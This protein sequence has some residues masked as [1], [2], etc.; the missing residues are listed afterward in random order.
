MNL[1]SIKMRASK[2]E[3]HISGGERIVNQDLLKD[4]VIQLIERPKDFDFMN[5]KIQ[6]LTE[7]RYIPTGL[8]I[9]TY[10]FNSVEDANRF[11]VEIINKATNIGHQIIDKYI[12]LVHTGASSTG[13]VMRGA[14]IVDTEG[15]RREIDRDRGIRTTNIDFEDREKITK[16]LLERG[17]SSRTVDALAIATKNLNSDYIL[18]EYCI[19]DDPEYTFGYVAI[20][21][22]YIRIYP[23]KEFGNPKGGRIYF[24]RKDTDIQRLYKYLEEDSFLIK[25]LGDIK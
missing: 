4:I 7:I 6:K 11:A 14:M 18:A 3:K 15:R 22:K 1:F 13:Q 25:D 12:K 21:G 2:D 19:S 17:F 24:I 5:I 9:Y 8:D 23:L 20:K 16:A 10:R